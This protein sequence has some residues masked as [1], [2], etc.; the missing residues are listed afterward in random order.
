M[1]PSNMRVSLMLKIKFRSVLFCQI[2]RNNKITQKC[3]RT[4]HFDAD[5]F[6]I[7]QNNTIIQEKTHNSGIRMVAS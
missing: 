6:C 3:V 7:T 4:V 2:T 1:A 5:R